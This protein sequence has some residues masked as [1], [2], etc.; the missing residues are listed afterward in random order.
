MGVIFLFLVFL[1]KSWDILLGCNDF[2]L[3]FV[4]LWSY[5]FFDE[6]KMIFSGRF[7]RFCLN[8][9]QN[10]MWEKNPNDIIL[11]KTISFCFCFKVELVFYMAVHARTT[12]TLN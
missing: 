5:F 11:L 9:T 7:H 6:F 3:V 1:I 2:K 10:N 4:Y 8:W 12:I